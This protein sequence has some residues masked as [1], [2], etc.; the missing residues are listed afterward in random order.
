MY[1]LYVDESG[2]PNNKNDNHFVLGG[3]AI[4]ERQIYHLNEALNELQQQ[5]FPTTTE[6]IEFHASDIYRRNKEPWHSLPR[7]RCQ[8]ILNSVYR[9]IYESHL[10]GVVLFSVVIDRNFQST[11]DLVGRAFEE[12][13]NRFDLYLTRLHQEQKSAN[14][15]ILVLLLAVNTGHSGR[16]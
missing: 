8:E 16:L 4:F 3:V 7:A 9:V 10:A 12:L 6:T 14:C 1:L 15:S 13:C 11:G 5:F 2:D